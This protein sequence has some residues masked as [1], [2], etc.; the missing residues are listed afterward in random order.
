[1]TAPYGPVDRSLC[2]RRVLV[3]G[4]VRGV[5]RAVAL[6]FARSGAGV[7]AGYRARHDAAARLRTE[8]A[9]Y[10]V[11]YTVLAADCTRAD[12][13]DRLAASAR[14]ALGGLDVLVNNVG[15]DVDAPFTDLTP[16]QWRAALD[17]NL[18]SQ[19][20]LAG[21][22]LPHLAPGGV[23]VNLCT[24]IL[25]SGSAGRAAYLAAKGGVLDLTRELARAYGPRGV[26]V[27]AIGPGVVR[28][29]DRVHL[30]PHVERR[31]RD[32]IPLGRLAEPG[33]I[34]GAVLFLAGDRSRYLTGI[35]LR[36]DGGM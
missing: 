2:G 18:T 25:A 15:A 4:G 11:P 19:A 35:H 7:A 13:V 33:E 1:V 20:L 27:N 12:E 31:F 9:G 28:T 14:D 8:L 30:P 10:G 22:V 24:S 6:A 17:V 23:I 16:D 34:A 21:A 3:T 26:R 29:E 32:L 36:V 5:G